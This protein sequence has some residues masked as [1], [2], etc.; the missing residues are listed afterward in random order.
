MPLRRKRLSL[1]LYE[2]V[3]SPMS[4]SDSSARSIGVPVLAL[5]RFWSQPVFP[6]SE[7]QIRRGITTLSLAKGGHI[8]H[9][10]WEALL[11]NNRTGCNASTLRLCESAGLSAWS[12]RASGAGRS[13]NG[14][15]IG[16]CRWQLRPK[17]RRSGHLRLS[18][19]LLPDQRA[20]PLSRRSANHNG[21]REDR[22]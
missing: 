20:R 21:W 18:R 22:H 19:P 1:C 15:E 7:S 17:T 14:S 9:S 5:F 3:S 11:P 10:L 12:L 16:A 13:Y 8:E 2:V 6:H 4:A